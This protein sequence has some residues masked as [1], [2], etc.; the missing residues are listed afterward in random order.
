MRFVGML[1]SNSGIEE[2]MNFCYG[3]VKPAKCKKNPIKCQS[4][5]TECIL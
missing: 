1:M 3:D 5:V 4:M 2:V